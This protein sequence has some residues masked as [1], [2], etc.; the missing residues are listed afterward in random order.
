[1]VVEILKYKFSNI[2]EWPTYSGGPLAR[3]LRYT[4]LG[5]FKIIVKILEVIYRL[6]LP[7]KIKIYPI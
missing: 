7:V 6:N 1:M 4:R 2:L 5:L 3:K